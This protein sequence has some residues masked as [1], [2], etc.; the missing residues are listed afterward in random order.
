MFAGVSRLTQAYL[1]LIEQ[2]VDFLMF[3]KVWS[4]M[5]CSSLVAHIQAEYSKVSSLVCFERLCQIYVCFP[6]LSSWTRAENLLSNMYTCIWEKPCGVA[7]P[8]P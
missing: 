2:S 6:R 1:G 5:V 7:V 8:T 3:F 4:I